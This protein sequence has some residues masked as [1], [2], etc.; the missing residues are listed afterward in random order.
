MMAVDGFATVL[1][2]YFATRFKKIAEKEKFGDL[3]SKQ[4][5]NLIVDNPVGELDDSQTAKIYRSRINQAFRKLASLNLYKADFVKD[6]L[7]LAKKWDLSGE[8]FITAHTDFFEYHTLPAVNF[9]NL[10]LT[11]MTAVVAKKY[12]LSLE[13]GFNLWR[14]F[15]D[16]LAAFMQKYD[17][18]EYWRESLQCLLLSGEW[19]LPRHASIICVEFYDDPEMSKPNP[20]ISFMVFKDTPAEEIKMRWKE[21]EALRKEVYPGKRTRN[22]NRKEAE[23]LLGLDTLAL[24][25]LVE[26]EMRRGGGYRK[27][28]KAKKMTMSRLRQDMYNVK[29][30]TLKIIP[31]AIQRQAD[32][33]KIKITKEY[34]F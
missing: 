5:R 7:T 30:E 24:G 10:H 1:D 16:D 21:V 29:P 15:Q 18:E 17:F 22:R 28:W 6:V 13:K 31:R 19:Y 34:I 4:N 33:L 2:I 25:D 14:F 3:I 32:V 11:A 27:T 26:K 23:K 9:W 12:N 8:V 20:R